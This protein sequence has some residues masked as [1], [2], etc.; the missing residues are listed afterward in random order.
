MVNM[1]FIEKMAREAKERCADRLKKSKV[2][3]GV[4]KVDDFGIGA[5]MKKN[6]GL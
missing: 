4:P 5:R 3:C 2:V 1:D 6:R